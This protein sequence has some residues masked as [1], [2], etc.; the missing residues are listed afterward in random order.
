MDDDFGSDGDFDF[1]TSNFLDGTGGGD[2]GGDINAMIAAGLHMNDGIDGESDDAFGGDRGEPNSKR[3]KLAMGEYASSYGGYN[4]GESVR[5]GDGENEDVPP[6]IEN[7]QAYLP[8]VAPD[9][10]PVVVNVLAQ[11]TIPDGPDLRKLSCATRNVEFMP[12]SRNASATMRLQDPNAVV[13]I[14]SSGSM[15][16]IG[17]ASISEARQAAEMAA[18]IIRKALNMEFRTFRF[19][20][21]SI[22]ARFNVCSPVRI[23]DLATFRLDRSVRTGLSE[24]HCSYEP[25]R[26]NGC[27]VKLV[28]TAQDNKWVVTCL[29]FVTGKITIMG[30][31]SADEL[32][33][34][35]DALVPILHKYIGSADPQE[36]DDLPSSVL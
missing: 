28:G 30:A 31:R 34:A 21:R 7:V 4:L 35:F 26:F 25:E 18:R 19:R 29:V 20:V 6:P 12:K 24:V 11:A 1:D 8:N 22:S 10:F 3:Q 16:I 33:F 5:N 9:A 32:R 2:D 27:V 36:Q 17:A 14:R 15:S 13:T 23:N